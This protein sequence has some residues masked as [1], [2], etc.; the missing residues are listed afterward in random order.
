MLNPVLCESNPEDEILD[1][2]A[3]SLQGW[4]GSIAPHPRHLVVQEGIVDLLQVFTHHHKTFDG[5][6]QLSQGIL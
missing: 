2:A 4:V 6:L 3:E 5:F 1:P